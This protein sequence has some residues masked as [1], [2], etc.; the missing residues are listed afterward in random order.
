MEAIG[1][2]TVLLFLRGGYRRSPCRG[3]RRD[4]AT[5]M[6]AG[7]IRLAPASWSPSVSTPSARPGGGIPR[8][9]PGRAK[10][11]SGSARPLVLLEN[12][13]LRVAV[14][15]R[16][17][18]RC[19]G[20]CLY[21]PTD[22]DFS[23]VHA[24]SRWR[25]RPGARRARTTTLGYLDWYPSGW[26]CCPAAAPSSTAARRHGSSDGQPGCHGTTRSADRQRR[27][28]PPC[29]SSCAAAMAARCCWSA[30]RRCAAGASITPRITEWLGE[31][32]K[33]SGR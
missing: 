1:A 22:L 29:A 3:V 24:S 4:S 8:R 18:R 14:L 11:S 20:A 9:T 17:R 33:S 30:Q 25:T 28:R 19:A 13:L 12:D 2:P 21:K 6:G 7:G 16:Q 32:S 26:R 27:R 15:A 10:I 23:L 5:L 31:Q